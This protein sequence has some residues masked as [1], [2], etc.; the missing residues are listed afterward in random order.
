MTTLDVRG[1]QLT[2]YSPEK[3]LTDLLRYA[4]RFGRELYLEGLRKY[5]GQRGVQVQAL[6][7]MGKDQGVWKELSRDLEVLLHDQDH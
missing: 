5:L 1:H 7:Q 4:P 2:T 3:T 6:I